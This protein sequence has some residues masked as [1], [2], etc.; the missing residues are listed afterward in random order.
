MIVAVERV[1]E[2]A[3]LP[4]EPTGGSV[5]PPPEWPLRGGIEIDGL[6]MRYRPE[7]PEVLRGLKCTIRP[8]EKVR[9]IKIKITIGMHCRLHR[10]ALSPARFCS[11]HTSAHLPLPAIAYVLRLLLLDLP[12]IIIIIIITIIALQVGICG[13]TGSGK[14]SLVSTLFR[15][16]DVQEGAIRI[17]GIEVGDVPLARLRSAM[18]ILP[19]D[20][21]LFSGSLRQNLDPTMQY[22]DKALWEVLGKVGMRRKVEALAARLEDEVADGG[23]NWSHGERQLLCMARALLQRRK[24]CVMDEATANLDAESD[25]VLQ[26]TI[27]REFSGATV[28]T[29][30]HRVHS[31]RDCDKILVLGDGLLLEAGSPDELLRDEN[32]AFTGLVRGLEE[33]ERRANADAAGGGGGGGGAA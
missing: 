11:F 2:Y 24:I 17:D 25:A 22:Q 12:V 15:L 19:Q 31:I 18:T 27:R 16:A 7:L 23:E 32:S 13:K 10:D 8:G 20:A 26:E 9:K 28:L 6:K 3:D 5:H 30:A 33:A 21:A 29:I 1:R 14:S 4:V